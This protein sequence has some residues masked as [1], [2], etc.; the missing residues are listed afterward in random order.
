MTTVRNT[1]GSAARLRMLAADETAW[2]ELSPD[3]REAVRGIV[4]RDEALG[5]RFTGV[6]YCFIFAVMFGAMSGVVLS[7]H[8]EVQ[9]WNETLCSRSGPVEGVFCGAFKPLCGRSRVTDLRAN[10][11]VTVRFPSY[12]P[13]LATWL[14]L[15]VVAWAGRIEA[16]PFRCFVR[17]AAGPTV[18]VTDRAIE[19]IYGWHLMAGLAVV[20]AIAEVML[21]AASQMSCRDNDRDHLFI[22]ENKH[23]E[24]F[25]RYRPHFLPAEPAERPLAIVVVSGIV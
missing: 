17:D 20:L 12:A 9:R 13:H 23:L 21:C 18:G 22:Q 5:W 24:R 1:T 16:G 3:D 4:R 19:G 10:R 8:Y 11:T 7:E 25:I 6:I 14:A 15:D 2:L